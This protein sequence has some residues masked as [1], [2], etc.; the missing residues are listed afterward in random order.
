MKRDLGG[1]RDKDSG[2]RPLRKNG[3][4]SNLGEASEKET[5]GVGG[6]KRRVYLV[7]QNR[8]A[9]TAATKVTGVGGSKSKEAHLELP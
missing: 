9:Q 4:S 6:G 2:E 7:P 8:V 3:E 5:W 1:E